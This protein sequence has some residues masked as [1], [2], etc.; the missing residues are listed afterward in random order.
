MKH[1][2]ICTCLFCFVFSSMADSVQL[3]GSQDMADQKLWRAFGATCSRE[4]D[5]GKTVLH[6]Q[7][8]KNEDSR[9]SWR[10]GSILP[11][12]DA[13]GPFTLSFQAELKDIVLNRPDDVWGGFI[14]LLHDWR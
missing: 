6:L 12:N 13:Y 10:A 7:K 2:F 3:L 14:I 4:E 9:C 1:L 5:A 8:M 11:G